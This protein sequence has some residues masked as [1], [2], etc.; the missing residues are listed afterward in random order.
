[1]I[2]RMFWHGVIA[3]LAAATLAGA[4]LSPYPF[5]PSTARADVRPA[6]AP[7]TVA[8]LAAPSASTAPPASTASSRG[9]VATRVIVPR[10]RINLPILQG[11]TSGAAAARRAYHYPGSG[12]P[13]S[14]RSTYLYGHARAG[15]FISLWKAR[16]GDR[17]ILTLKNGRK[18]YY[19]AFSVRLIKW[20]DRKWLFA[21]GEILVLQTCVG[22]NPKGPRF[23]VLANRTK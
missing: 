13:G 3:V 5:A 23:V 8:T 11:T 1:M 16:V 14:G 15:T 22:R 2:D 18:A 7:A 19:R 9:V 4:S 6:A 21:S 10:L 20:H 12:W 17:I